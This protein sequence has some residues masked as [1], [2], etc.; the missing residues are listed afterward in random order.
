MSA[1]K[2]LRD[3]QRQVKAVAKDAN[4]TASRA[5]NRGIQTARTEASKIIRSELKLKAGYV[6]DNL[7]IIRKASP[8]DLRAIISSRKRGIMMSNYPHREMKS[9]GVSVQIKAGGGRVLLRSAFLMRFQNGKTGIMIRTKSNRGVNAVGQRRSSSY[10]LQTLYS[11]SASQA[12]AQVREE[13]TA[14]ASDKVIEEYMRLRR[15]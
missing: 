11:P 7:R 2:Q 10:G 3:A 8:N 4:R 12:F 15:L 14:V 9:G 13:V 5:L 6:R 1:V